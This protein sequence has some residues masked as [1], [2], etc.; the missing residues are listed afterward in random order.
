MSTFKLGAKVFLI[1]RVSAY[2]SA[3]AYTLMPKFGM[4]VAHAHISLYAK[5][6]I[7]RI[8]RFTYF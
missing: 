7:V 6:K 5:I 1:I 8:N 4:V 2:I 3:T